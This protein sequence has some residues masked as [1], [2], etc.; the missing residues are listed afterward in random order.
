MTKRTW[1]GPLLCSAWAAIT[2]YHRLG[3]LENRHLFLHSSGSWRPKIRM[4]S[5]LRSGES[6]LPGLKIVT[7]S[8]GPYMVGKERRKGERKREK[9]F[10]SISSYKGTNPNISSPPSYDP[11][12]PNEC[13]TPL[14][15]GDMFQDPQWMPA[16]AESM[17][18][19]IYYVFSYTSIPLIKFNL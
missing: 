17:E 1:E 7:F 5:W 13:R 12:K 18:P 11:F 6:S 10:S 8:L 15:V 16:T 3:G 4:P 19:Q 9:E 2:K 14:S